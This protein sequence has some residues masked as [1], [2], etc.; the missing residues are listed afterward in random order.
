MANPL[1]NMLNQGSGLL[2]SIMQMLPG[3]KQNPLGALQRAGYSVPAGV[4]TPQQILQHLVQ[5]GQINQ[6]QLNFAQQ[7]AQNL[8]IK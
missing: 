5:S 8:G 7:M 4:S 6:N 3:M 2:G 1:F